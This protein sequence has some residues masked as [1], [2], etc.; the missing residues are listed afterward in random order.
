MGLGVG[1]FPPVLAGSVGAEVRHHIVTAASVMVG[2]VVE[3]EMRGV[4]EGCRCR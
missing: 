1:V 4:Y 2:M 3:M